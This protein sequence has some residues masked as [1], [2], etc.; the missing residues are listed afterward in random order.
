M[1]TSKHVCWGAPP[2]NNGGHHRQEA[3]VLNSS[4]SIPINLHIVTGRN[5][6]KTKIPAVYLLHPVM[7]AFDLTYAYPLDTEIEEIPMS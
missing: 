4:R 1:V 7:Y 5:N 2:S 6:P 3:F